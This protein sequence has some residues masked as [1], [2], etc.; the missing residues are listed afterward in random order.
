MK[1][2]LPI[3][4]SPAAFA[5]M[6]RQASIIESPDA[7]LEA[8]VAVAMHQIKDV[9]S[10]ATD[11]VIQ[12][13]ADAVRKRVRGEQAQAMLAHLHQFLFDEQRFLGNED[14]Y[15]D[16]LNSYLPVVL[17]HRRGLPI[18]LS[19]IYKLV[20]E[21]LGLRIHGVG[22]P[23][24][25]IVAVE[26][27]SGES[28]MLVDPFNRGRVLTLDDARATVQDTY[29]REIEWSE[30]LLSPVSNLHWI[31]RILQNLL[32]GFGKVSQF[33]NVAAMLELEML[34]WPDEVHLQRDL[35]LVLARIGLPR[36]A[37]E[38]LD[39]YLKA[40]PGDPQR[41]DLEQLLDVLSA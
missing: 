19:L 23:G 21:R 13:Y 14:D 27:E 36:P 6:A 2:L 1:S 22:L 30:D 12:S 40:N 3:C 28:A 7:L 26:D 41:G 29:G 33:E 34:L 24:H 5:A 35:A 15:H 39:H 9:S 8:A 10:T 38:W 32:H 25:F 37:S 16:P 4:C 31:T 18:T 17:K 20:G 11:R